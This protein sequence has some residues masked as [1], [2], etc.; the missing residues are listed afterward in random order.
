[1]NRGTRSVPPAPYL[2]SILATMPDIHS[3]INNVEP[4]RF[5]SPSVE[6]PRA[7]VFCVRCGARVACELPTLVLIARNETGEGTEEVVRVMKQ[8]K[9]MELAKHGFTSMKT[10]PRR[11][12]IRSW[13]SILRPGV[14]L[15]WGEKE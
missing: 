7:V 4:A 8:E 5:R 6:H 12:V 1:M 3:E 11:L 14:V 2:L 13:Q 15:C 10:I 9:N